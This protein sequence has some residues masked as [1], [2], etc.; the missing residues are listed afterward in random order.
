MLRLTFILCLGLLLQRS[1]GAADI[2]LITSSDSA[3]YQEFAGSLRQGLAGSKWQIKHSG[4]QPNDDPTTDLIITAGPDALQRVLE[5]GT[6]VPVLATLLPA[7]TYQLILSRHK[8]SGTV[9]AIYLD[10][11]ASR[12]ARLLRLLLP[13]S[14][15]IGIISSDAGQLQVQAFRPA[16]SNQRLQIISET[17]RSEDE[18][19]RRLETLLPRV[20]ALLALP[21]NLVYSRNTVR[22]LLITT[23]RFRRPLIGFSAALSKAGA[24][25]A[26]YSTPTQIA[27]QTSELIITHGNRLPPARGPRE[28]SLN[29]NHSVASTFDISL[30]DEADL[31]QKMINAG[32]E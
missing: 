32:D 9:S 23:Y 18:L 14:Q 31:L 19:I 8:P 29:I 4:S 16:F 1:V 3:P 11:P 25:A 6:R 10:Q 15:N 22:P 30:P 24:L 5:K 12:Q 13:N 26:L 17:I 20:D 7:S 28:F 27:R 21:D 2:A